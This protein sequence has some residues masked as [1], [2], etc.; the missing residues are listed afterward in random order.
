MCDP[1]AARLLLVMCGSTHANFWL[2]A[3]APEHVK[4]TSPVTE[5]HDKNG[6]GFQ[7]NDKNFIKTN[8]DKNNS[9]TKYTNKHKDTKYNVRDMYE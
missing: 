7:D 6:Y 8:V 3:V 5:N 4:S 1:Q 9:D 2:R